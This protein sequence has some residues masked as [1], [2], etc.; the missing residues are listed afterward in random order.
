MRRY[1]I[2]KGDGYFEVKLQDEYDNYTKTYFRTLES[3]NLFVIKW[4]EDTEKRNEEV[5]LTN[6]A[7]LNCIE[8]DRR[9]GLLTNNEDNLD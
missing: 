9:S 7:I 1:D 4:F 5:N 8:I 6:R 2:T 3:A